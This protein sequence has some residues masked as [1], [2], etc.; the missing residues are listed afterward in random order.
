M[1]L[2]DEIAFL[3]L[4]RVMWSSPRDEVDEERL[5]ASYLGGTTD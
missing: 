5:A 2:A 1:E 3:E 4:G